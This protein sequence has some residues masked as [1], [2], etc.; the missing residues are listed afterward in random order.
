MAHAF[1]QAFVFIQLLFVSDGFNNESYSQVV[2]IVIVSK[3]TFICI[4]NHY[5]IQGF[6]NHGNLIKLCNL[7]VGKF[8]LL[9]HF[10]LFNLHTLKIAKYFIFMFKG[11]KRP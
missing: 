2:G 1:C 7:L 6:L 9:R 3:G 5:S 8:V 10:Y 4:R 11:N